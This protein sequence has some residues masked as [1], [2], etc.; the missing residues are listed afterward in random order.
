MIELKT[1]I[2]A[3]IELRRIIHEMSVVDEKLH[4]FCIR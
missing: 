4:R 2:A 3:Q 1:A